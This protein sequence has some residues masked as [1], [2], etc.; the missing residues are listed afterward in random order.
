MDNAKDQFEVNEQFSTFL[1]WHHR[2]FTKP[3]SVDNEEQCAYQCLTSCG[4]DEV[5]D[6]Y[7]FHGGFCSLGNLKFQL[8]DDQFSLDLDC[9]PVSKV[10]YNKKKS[11]GKLRLISTESMLIC[12]IF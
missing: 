5:C 1:T 11:A 4:V 12:V 6:Y 7:A 8:E 3:I 9:L 2:L 10:M